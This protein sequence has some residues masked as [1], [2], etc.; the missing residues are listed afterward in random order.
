MLPPRLALPIPSE[1]SLNGPHHY[2]LHA[3]SPRPGTTTVLRSFFL[4]RAAVFRFL[5]AT[6]CRVTNQSEHSTVQFHSLHLSHMSD[7]P[8][9]GGVSSMRRSTTSTPGTGYMRSNQIRQAMIP[10]GLPGKLSFGWTSTAHKAP[11]SWGQSRSSRP[12]GTST[13][14]EEKSSAGF[15]NCETIRGTPTPPHRSASS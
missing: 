10:S 11:L 13:T 15:W 2:F 12:P 6:T 8:T 7:R 5:A 4:A 3:G 14:P 9:E 1:L